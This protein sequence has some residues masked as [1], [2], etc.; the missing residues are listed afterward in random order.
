MTYFGSKT[1]VLAFLLSLGRGSPSSCVVTGQSG[2]GA[3]SAC[4]LPI[5]LPNAEI[6]SW[7]VGLFEHL[8]IYPGAGNWKMLCNGIFFHFLKLKCTHALAWRWKML[9]NS[10]QYP[11]ILCSKEKEG[12]NSILSNLI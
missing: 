1:R 4:L 2:T 6:N 9:C 8:S 10:K 12:K 3:D 7:A 11:A 5:C